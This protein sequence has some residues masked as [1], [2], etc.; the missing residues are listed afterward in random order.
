MYLPCV[1]EPRERNEDELDARSD[2]IEHV[3]RRV[4]KIRAKHR[5]QVDGAPGD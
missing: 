1:T 4:V 3:L 2:A 5:E